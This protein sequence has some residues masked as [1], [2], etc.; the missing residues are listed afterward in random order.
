[1]ALLPESVTAGSAT[2]VEDS[3][4]AWKKLNDA[5][6]LKEDFG[7]V[8]DGVADDS[9]AVANWLAAGGLLYAPPGTYL[10]GQIAIPHGCHMMGVNSGTYNNTFSDTQRT[11]FKLKNATNASHVQIPITSNRVIITDIEFD[12]NKGNQSAGSWHG[13]NF[14]ADTVQNEAQAILE[15]VYTHDYKGSGIRVDGWRQAVHMRDVVSNFNGEHGIQII[16]TDCIID[17]PIC[18]DNTAVGIV[19]SGNVT[20]VK[21]GAIYNNERGIEIT[22]GTKRV[23]LLGNGIDKNLRA[24]IIV[25]STC[26]GISILGTKM[27]SNGR[28]TDNTYP[29]I[30]VQTT[31]GF[32]TLIGNSF[33]PLEPGVTN[34]TNYAVQLAAGATAYDA[35]NNYEGGSDGGYTNAPE[36]LY[37]STR[38]VFRESQQLWMDQT[39]TPLAQGGLDLPLAKTELDSTFQGTRRLLDLTETGREA[40][41]AVRGRRIAGTGSTTVVV[42]VCEAGTPANVLCSVTLTFGA[43][44]SNITSGNAGVGAWTTLPAWFSTAKTVAVFTEVT[45]GGAGTDDY[46]F[47]DVTLKWRG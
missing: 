5:P 27:T 44:P 4:Q 15:R 35:G 8:G 46:V 21:G 9:A 31:T 19:V 3:N 47:R 23:V 30:D 38:P 42:S 29:H 24:G 41:V 22:T 43:A 40:Q 2:H 37:T 16:G 34:N 26:A 32:V 12:G 6:N 17:N 39:A 36:R 33:S 45:S 11:R 14:A 28:Q 25:A 10:T 18:G 1:V 7:A 20:V 13:I